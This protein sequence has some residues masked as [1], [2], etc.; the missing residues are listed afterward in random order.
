MRL[1]TAKG[2]IIGGMIVTTIYTAGL[3]I[4]YYFGWQ[5]LLC[6]QFWWSCFP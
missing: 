3:I 6:S 2:I 5:P 1:E 4:H